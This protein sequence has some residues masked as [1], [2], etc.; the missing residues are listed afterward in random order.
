MSTEMTR[1]VK[2]LVD[3]K[4][5]LL[6]QQIFTNQDIYKMEL[7]RIFSRCWLFLGHETQ[8]PERNDFFTTYMGEDPIILQRDPSGKIRAYLNMCRHRGTRVC[9]TDHGKANSFKCPYHGWV[10][11]SDGGKLVNVPAFKEAYYSELSLEKYGLVEV[12]QLD[13]YKGL[14]FGN[15]DP[16]APPLLDYLGDMTWYMDMLFDRHESGT[17][18]MGRVYK[19]VGDFNWKLAADNFGGDA[20]HVP[21]THGS[22]IQV[23]FTGPGNRSFPVPG[24]QITPGNGHSMGCRWYEDGDP[25][26]RARTVR[27]GLVSYEEEIAGG[28][29][30]RL[31]SIRGRQL[32]GIHAT[33]FPNMSFLFNGALRVWHP[34]GPEQTEIWAWIFVDKAA[35]P[36][37]KRLVRLTSMLSFG[38]SGT[39]EQDD[40]DNWGQSTKA[41]RGAIARRYPANIQMGLGHEE[42]SEHFPGRYGV[43]FSEISQRAMY[44]RWAEMM[45]AE[46]WSDISL[47]PRTREVETHDS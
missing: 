41:A 16:H 22:A 2:R 46:S 43:W 45:A 3:T 35:P 20:Y 25:A 27:P 5:G 7:E 24:F 29:E 18:V 33:V 37:V 14:I 9:R 4:Q 23:G 44:A 26:R 1:N 36:E 34:K 10:Y 30:R 15:W 13:T 38:P 32:Q 11:S 21:F 47:A 42:T 6:D 39:F 40:M 31:G 17:E 19:W 12:T 28:V 8:I